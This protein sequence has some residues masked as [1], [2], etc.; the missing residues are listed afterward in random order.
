MRIGLQRQQF[1]RARAVHSAPP[2]A[3]T[4]IELI[5]VMTLLTVAISVTAPALANFFRGRSL[6]SEARRLLALTHEGQ[7]RAVSEGVPID[8]WIDASQSKFG[9]EA[10]TSYEAEDAKAIE[11][12]L[13]ADVQLEVVSAIGGAAS[14]QGSL[15]STLS[16]SATQSAARSRHATLPKISFLPDGTVAT[17]SPQA[18]R[19]RSRDDHVL[20]VGLSRN[21]M[22]YELRT[23]NQ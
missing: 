18:V 5:L 6:D 21:R 20:E 10:Q 11:F 1:L 19:I 15:R 7:S 4:L 9:L 12:T 14:Q 22:N 3:F 17:T 2:R 16:A 13:E 23:S 8:L